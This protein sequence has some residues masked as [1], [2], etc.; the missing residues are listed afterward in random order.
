[1]PRRVGSI[2][3]WRSRSGTTSSGGSMAAATGAR[4]TA[5][6]ADDERGS[7]RPAVSSSRR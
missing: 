3:A 4:R 1:V 7:V 5:P 2:H 6:R